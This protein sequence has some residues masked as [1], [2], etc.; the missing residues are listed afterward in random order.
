MRCL[1]FILALVLGL[2]GSPATATTEPGRSSVLNLA[3]QGWVYTLR[4]SMMRR[5]GGTA[6]PVISARSL[7]GARLCLLGEDPH[8]V[9]R[10]VLNRFSELMERTSGVPLQIDDAIDPEDCNGQRVVLRLF[11]RRSP[12]QEYNEDLNRLDR[13]FA[14]G[15]PRR[16]R[17]LVAS[18]AQAQTFFGRR[19]QA[20]HILIMQPMA[21]RDLTE[22]ARL[23]YTSILIE[24][25]YQAFTF[26]MD[27]ILFDRETPPMSKL[28]ESP[29]SLRGLPW[30]SDAFMRG[31]LSSN[32][33]G[34]CAF[35]ILMLHALGE[36]NLERTNSDALL[37]YLNDNYGRLS[38]AMRETVAMSDFAPLLDPACRNLPD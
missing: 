6:M 28:Q 32:P 4:S 1:G 34:L 33:T 30:R 37:R 27:V 23:F 20:T 13:S 12:H 25:L 2:T 16:R 24:E 10:E 14:I 5:P 22:V 38:E 11:S 29:V 36:S 18:P 9:T 3:R 17:H 8:P 19:G 7:R 21:D 35:D 26:G 15:L 31:L